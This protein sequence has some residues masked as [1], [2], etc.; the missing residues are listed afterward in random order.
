MTL[1]D[2]KREI[3]AFRHSVLTYQLSLYQHKQIHANPTLVE[4]RGRVSAAQMPVCNRPIQAK[5]VASVTNS[6]LGLETAIVPTVNM[7]WQLTVNAGN[8][9]A[10][11][12]I[13]N[14]D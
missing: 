4:D 11:Y 12:F 5:C 2:R 1:C 9:S 7:G 3:F 6:G 10:N 8:L 13:L 14:E